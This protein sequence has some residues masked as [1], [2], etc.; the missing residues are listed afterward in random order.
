MEVKAQ[1]GYKKEV[2]STDISL[3]L[4]AAL[5]QLL[6]E[7]DIKTYYRLIDKSIYKGVFKV[8]GKPLLHNVFDEFNVVRAVA[9]AIRESGIANTEVVIDRA[10]RRL[11]DGKFDSFN[12]YLTTKVKKMCEGENRVNHITHVNS[13]YVSAMQMSDIV[14]GAIRDNF[15]KKNEELSKLI[16]PERLVLADGKYENQLRKKNR[17]KI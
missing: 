10:D 12:N 4:Y 2:K 14:G 9:Y 1:A 16:S 3:R 7:L 5:L 8:D 17:H 13:D 15:T 11:L 6:N